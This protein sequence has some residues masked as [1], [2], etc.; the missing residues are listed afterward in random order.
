MDKQDKVQDKAETQRSPIR[1]AL[2]LATLIFTTVALLLFRSDDAHMHKLL[3]KFGGK[4]GGSAKGE[5]QD[6]QQAQEFPAK[7][8]AEVQ[9]QQGPGRKVAVAYFVRARC[10]SHT[11]RRG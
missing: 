6:V 2:I 3:S 8:G 1:S 9:M 7:T 10:P 5:Q 11:Y 4:Q